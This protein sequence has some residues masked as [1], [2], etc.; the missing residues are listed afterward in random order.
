MWLQMRQFNSN[1]FFQTPNATC[2]PPRA[3]SV[4]DGQAS[5]ATAIDP[6]SWLTARR[7]R[8]HGVLMAVCL[9]TVYAVAMSTPGLRDRNGLIKGTDFLQFYTLG[10]LALQRRGD[11][12]YD[13][14]AQSAV[15]Q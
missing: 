15:T 2:G 8:I 5:M 3:H 13:M 4:Y 1:Q 7:V 11:L 14:W 6:V 12:L 9:W 10:S